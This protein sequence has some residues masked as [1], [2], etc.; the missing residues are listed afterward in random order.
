MSF[1]YRQKGM[2]LGWLMH[3]STVLGPVSGPLTFPGRIALP[4]TFRPGSAGSIPTIGTTRAHPGRF[5]TYQIR[6]VLFT[7]SNRGGMKE[8]GIGRENGLE[9][10]ESCWSSV[11]LSLNI[12]LSSVSDSQSKSTIVN[13]A[14]AETTRITDDWFSEEPEGKRYG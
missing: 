7:Y 5:H 13:I 4:L 6:C 10:F 11:I 2:A 14:S 9:A 12:S 8:S 3:A 1:P